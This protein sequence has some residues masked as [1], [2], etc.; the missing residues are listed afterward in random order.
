ANKAFAFP[1]VSNAG[2]LQAAGNAEW[3]VLQNSARVQSVA[4]ESGAGCLSEEKANRERRNTT[5]TVRHT[6]ST[7][8]G[9]QSCGMRKNLRKDS[10]NNR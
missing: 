3:Q 10:E 7:T 6:A 8:E 9:Q 5:I 4:K 1:I 2:I